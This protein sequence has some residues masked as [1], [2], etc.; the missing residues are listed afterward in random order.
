[1]DIDDGATVSQVQAVVHHAD[2]LNECELPGHMPDAPDNRKISF[3]EN[4]TKESLCTGNP[5][6]EVIRHRACNRSHSVQ[7]PLGELPLTR[8]IFG[9]DAQFASWL[10]RRHR[11]ELRTYSHSAEPEET[12]MA[13]YLRRLSPG[14]PSA[15]NTAPPVDT[16]RDIHPCPS[17]PFTYFHSIPES[18]HDP[19]TADD[20]SPHS[21]AQFHISLRGFPW[22]TCW[23]IS[24]LWLC[25]AS[26]LLVVAVTF[27][28]S[29][30]YVCPV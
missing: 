13:R 26:P 20:R 28:S 30:A 17:F 23:S 9:S 27:A 12:S 6:S 22:Y 7:S 10:G 24:A 14:S 18:T 2:P 1:M 3:P 4:L 19:T 25:S 5:P 16:S 8:T 11:Y 29:V 15:P 21:E